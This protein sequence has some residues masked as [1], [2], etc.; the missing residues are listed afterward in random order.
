[1]NN[2]VRFCSFALLLVVFTGCATVKVERYVEEGY[3]SLGREGMQ[4]FQEPGTF[5]SGLPVLPLDAPADYEILAAIDSHSLAGGCWVSSTI[6]F[7]SK[8]VVNRLIGKAAALGAN[9]IIVR[10]FRVNE[11]SPERFVR[12]WDD[13]TCEYETVYKKA[14]YGVFARVEAIYINESLVLAK[15]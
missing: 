8:Q 13:E 1:M 10:D 2:P 3:P 15:R 5:F 6:R 7:Q 4:I 12:V 11:C 14:T 9:G